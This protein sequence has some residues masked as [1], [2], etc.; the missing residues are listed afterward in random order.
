MEGDVACKKVP[1]VF[2]EVIKESWLSRG[3]PNNNKTYNGN[4]LFLLAGHVGKHNG[5]IS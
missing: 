5:I 2:A 4:L 3:P 1:G